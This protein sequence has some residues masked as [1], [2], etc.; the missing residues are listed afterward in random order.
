M[1]NYYYFRECFPYLVCRE[2]RVIILKNRNYSVIYACTPPP[3][4]HLSWKLMVDSCAAPYE[5]SVRED[6]FYLYDDASNPVNQRGGMNS[7]LM[8][9][10][11]DRMLS[12]IHILRNYEPVLVGMPSDIN[13]NTGRFEPRHT[14]TN[15]GTNTC[16]K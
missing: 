9:A 4:S 2:D 5:D 1:S 11:L 15:Y 7:P 13:F 16:I 14:L 12:L 8:S 3:R 10:Y 6:C